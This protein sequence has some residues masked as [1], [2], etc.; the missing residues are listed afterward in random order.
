[1]FF[2]E[3]ILDNVKLLLGKDTSDEDELIIFLIEDCIFEVLSYCRIN[4]LPN[5][6]MGVVAQMTAE[7]YRLNGYGTK[8]IP[9]DIKSISE[10]DRSISFEKRIGNDGIM[11]NYK[12]RL[13]PF[14]NWRGRV[15]SSIKNS[16][17]MCND[18][19]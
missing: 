7:R 9:T 15:P 8:E 2:P 18:K 5:R 12:S 13:A 10:G 4:K 3:E 19:E 17:D 1:M 16:E 6:L 14:V 11:N